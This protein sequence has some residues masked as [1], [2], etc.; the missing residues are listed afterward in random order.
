MSTTPHLR[1]PHLALLAAP[2]LLALVLLGAAFGWMQA[3]HQRAQQQLDDL[4]PRYARLLGMQAQQGEITQALQ[5]IA[6]VKAEHVYPGEIDATQTGN[7]LQQRLRDALT[8]AGLSVLSSQVRVVPNP[9][10]EPAPYQRIDVL[11][12]VDGSWEAVQMALLA[13]AELRPSV[14]LDDVRITLMGN[15]QSNAAWQG[16]RSAANRPQMPARPQAPA[17]LQAQL[18]FHIL[19]SN[20]AS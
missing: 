10:T 5:S 17:R 7:A 20:I 11:V 15:L 2:L 8:R 1:A 4:A 16:N 12:S 3:K 18:V 9:D 14:W 19:R 6:A 13:T